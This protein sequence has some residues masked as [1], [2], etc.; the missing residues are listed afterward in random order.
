MSLERRQA[1]RVVETWVNTHALA[2]S[3]YHRDELES[4]IATALFKVYNAA[5]DAGRRSGPSVCPKCGED[6][7]K[8]GKEH[9]GSRT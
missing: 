2:I 9:G 7:G 5:Y 4:D 6:L 8:K 1:R 3:Q